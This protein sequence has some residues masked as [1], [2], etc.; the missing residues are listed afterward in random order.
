M[1]VTELRQQYDYLVY[2]CALL[3]DKM[4]RLREL[5]EEQGEQP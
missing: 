5:L 2:Q 4:E 1:T 3:E